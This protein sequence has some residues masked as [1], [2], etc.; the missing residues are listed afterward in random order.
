M[1]QILKYNDTRLEG[2]CVYCGKK[3]ETKD[4]VP[5]K[6]LL[7]KPYPENLPVVPACNDCNQGFSKDEEYF[8]CLLECAL[9]GTTDPEKLKRKKIKKILTTKPKLLYR[10]TEAKKF[11]DG[12]IFFKPEDKRIKNVVLKLAR[13]HAF[14]ENSELQLDKTT[15]INIRPIELMTDKELKKYFSNEI[16]I[17]PEIGSRSFQRLFFEDDSAIGSWIN[18][19]DNNY[20]YSVNLNSEISIKFLIWNYLACEVIWN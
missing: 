11:I 7:N 20:V 6:I 4:H 5:S 2:Y 8:A 9:R 17:F 12:Q 15:T 18:V 19:Q 3:P 14:Y 10:L 13:G 16:E 1:K